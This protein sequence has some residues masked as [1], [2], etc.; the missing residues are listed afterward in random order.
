VGG[1]KG[2][3]GRGWGGEGARTW[4]AAKSSRSS[5]GGSEEVS[6]SSSMRA[7][8]AIWCFGC[9]V[10]ETEGGK[11]EMGDGSQAGVCDCK[12]RCQRV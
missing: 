8:W 3:V 11:W 9:F 12:A 2:R 4:V 7:W 1:G 5:S 10:G 6:E